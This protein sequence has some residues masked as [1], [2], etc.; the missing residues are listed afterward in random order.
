FDARLDGRADQA[1][2]VAGDEVVHRALEQRSADGVEG[3]VG[4]AELHSAPTVTDIVQAVPSAGLRPQRLADGL[5]PGVLV[6]PDLGHALPRS[7]DPARPQPS[8]HREGARADEA[9]ALLVARV[10]D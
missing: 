3:V 8:R 7:S 4:L 2:V 1:V 9:L 6:G 5:V 10:E